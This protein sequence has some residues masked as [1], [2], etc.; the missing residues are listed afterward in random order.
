MILFQCCGVFLRDQ[1]DSELYD[2]L[3][4]LCGDAVLP[5]MLYRFSEYI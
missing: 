3:Y 1:Q 4:E 2:V 5:F